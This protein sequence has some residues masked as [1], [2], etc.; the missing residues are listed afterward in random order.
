LNDNEK[1]RTK[2]QRS[3]LRVLI[4]FLGSMNLAITMLVAVAIASVIGT[5]LKQNEP[6]TNYVQK[7]G[8]YW[9]EVFKN[10]G[11]FD[12]YGAPWFL[13]LLGLLLVST[14]ICVYRNTPSIIKDMR[15]FRLDV[16]GKSLRAFKHQDEW[17]VAEKAGESA[18]V[19]EQRLKKLGYR[20]RRKQRGDEVVVAAM[21]GSVSRLG[22]LLSHVAIV[23]ICIGGLIDG[24]L[25]LKL[26]EL[27]GE[28]KVETRDLPLTQ[29]PD[30]SILPIDNS[31]FRGSVNIPEGSRASVVFLGLRD[32][33]L[34]QPL[35][36]S[37][38]L[39]DFR[40]QHYPSGKP[41]SFESTLIIHDDELKEPM[42]REIAVN[43]PLI[44][45]DYAI[46]QA[47]FTDGGSKLKLKAWSLD[48]PKREPLEID[49]E[50][51]SQVKLDTPRGEYNL[52][53]N[54][55]KVFNIFP[56]PEND[57][58]GK[59]YHNYGPSVVFKLR[60][61]NGEAREYV[62]Y[63]APVV[64]DGRPYFLTGMR[65]S[66][67]EEYRFMHLP[68]DPDGG[69]GRF[70]RLLAMAHDEAKVREV[71]KRQAMTEMGITPD[72]PIY[73]QFT[74]SMVGL[75][76]TFVNDG[77]D[78]V[79]AKAEETIAEDKRQEAMSSYIQIIQS[80]LGTFY[81][82]LLHD[83]GVDISGGISASDASYFD[84]AVNAIS[85]LGPYGSPMYIKLEDF[86]QVQASGLQI[87]KAPGQN[88]V[89]L[90]CVM[91]MFGVFFMFYLHHRRVWLLITPQQD[92]GSSV[93]LAAT[94][95]RERSDFDREFT[96][97]QHDLRRC[98]GES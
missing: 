79:V 63:M 42:K 17:Q 13:V 32:G 71:A 41:K 56:L 7:F 49:S 96:F 97:L 44:Y 53:L 54:D 21:K 14:S 5:V 15:H 85:L 73:G 61:A 75:V 74:E 76:R 90:G 80:V 24:N 31:S 84:D 34:V 81:I 86:T 35:P 65:T 20:S 82:E 12:I 4:E 58:S 89:Y 59:K 25:P 60:A 83:D 57:P 47:S 48:E 78:A 98:S 23:V 39:V 91:L 30:A 93:L 40:I 46:Y 88:I 66:P 33:Y 72:N 22:Y 11:L 62:N 94:G 29:I 10:L 77:I 19:L 16:Q 18:N 37:V 95:H 38:E 67:A 8:P 6:Y 69:V 27:S 45:K 43:H 64:V 70:M 1:Q 9:F 51:S 92:G 28:L 55:L 36:F 3:L 68:V 2:P 50:V 26:K 52:E 87:T